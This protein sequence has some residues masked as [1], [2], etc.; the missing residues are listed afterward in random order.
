MLHIAD[1]NQIYHLACPRKQ[2]YDDDPIQALELT[3]KSTKNLLD[4]ALRCNAKV[5]FASMTEGGITRFQHSRGSSW[6]GRLRKR[7][8]KRSLDPTSPPRKRRHTLTNLRT[9]MSISYHQEGNRTGETLC[10]AYRQHFGL[11]VRVVRIIE[12]AAE[13]ASGGRGEAPPTPIEPPVETEGRVVSERL[14]SDRNPQVRMLL[15]AMAATGAE[16]SVRKSIG[17]LG[18]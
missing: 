11:D 3:F 4:V 17:P 1:V 16:T 2:D 5:V 10:S 12:V 8:H 18:N 14:E 15:E 7:K 9:P 13:V 6:D